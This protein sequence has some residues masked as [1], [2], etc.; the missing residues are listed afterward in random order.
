MPVVDQKERYRQQAA[1]CYEIAAGLAGERATSM[2]RLGDTYG[3]L[4]VDPYRLLPNIF[5]SRKKYVDPICPKCGRKMQLT[6]SLPRTEILPAMQAFR[7]D[8]CRETLIWKGEAPSPR[9]A[10]P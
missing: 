6:H 9:R 10:R 4:A 2:I 7:C 5:A 3:A 8:A 1:L